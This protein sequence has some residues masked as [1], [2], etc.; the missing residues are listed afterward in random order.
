M[1]VRESKSQIQS[2]DVEMSP[3]IAET[4]ADAAGVLAVDVSAI[5]AILDL[6]L[7]LSDFHQ[8]QWFVEDPSWFLD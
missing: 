2:I 8:I 6:G 7:R 4:L 5:S 1:E 3:E